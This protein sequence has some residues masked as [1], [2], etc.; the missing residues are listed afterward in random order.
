[1]ANYI[2]EI[3]REC[4]QPATFWAQPKGAE[5]QEVLRR[6]GMTPQDASAYLGISVNSNGRTV[7]KW[8]SEEAPIP[9]SA[10]ALLCD[11]AGFEPFWRIDRD[12]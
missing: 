5:V 7:R 9:Y 2:T 12:K 4:L 11:A 1:M 8:M 3:R 6:T 10:W